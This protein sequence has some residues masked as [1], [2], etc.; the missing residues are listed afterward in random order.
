MYIKVRVATEVKKEVFKRINEDTFSVSVKEPAEQNRANTRVRELIASH[1]GISIK[2]VR[3]VS[4]HHSP[5]KI[6]NIEYQ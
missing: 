4:G 3:F 1:F 5:S 6:F 2:G